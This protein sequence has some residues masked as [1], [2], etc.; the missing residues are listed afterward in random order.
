L[1][2]PGEVAKLAI[3]DGQ[4]KN[5]DVVL[6]DTAGRMQN[7]DKL[8]RELAKLVQVFCDIAQSLR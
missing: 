8:M 4:Q 7:N 3:A 6:I 2:D 1:K 5:M